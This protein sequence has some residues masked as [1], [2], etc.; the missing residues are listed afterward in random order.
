VPG[1]GGGLASVGRII[2]QKSRIITQE[3]T[4]VIP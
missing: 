3:M 1:T 2:T 4:R